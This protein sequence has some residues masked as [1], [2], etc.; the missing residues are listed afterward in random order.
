MAELYYLPFKSRKI[1]EWGR[2]N[3]TNI[4]V[5]NILE[6]LLEHKYRAISNLTPYEL[7]C[8]RMFEYSKTIATMT[9][10]ATGRKSPVIV[11]CYEIGKGT[12]R[13]RYYAYNPTNK[14]YYFL[15]R[16]ILNVPNGEKQEDLFTKPYFLRRP[17]EWGILRIEFRKK[18]KYSE[19]KY[20]ANLK[21]NIVADEKLSPSSLDWDD[22]GY[23]PDCKVARCIGTIVY[24]G[25]IL[26][27][28]IYPKY[29]NSICAVV[30][31]YTYDPN[32]EIL[33]TGK[34]RHLFDETFRITSF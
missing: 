3:S 29:M 16:E 25:K 30:R 31:Y 4:D 28:L 26:P 12:M 11:K 20:I 15:F 8:S 19:E 1:D 5:L 22:Y 10:P 6:F 21:C 13:L 2:L 23:I 33:Y 14:T 9:H 27:L 18:G 17:G 32:G 7:S 34:F 24:N